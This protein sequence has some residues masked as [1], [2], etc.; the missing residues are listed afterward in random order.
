MNYG[1]LGGYTVS[2]DQTF[3]A[4]DT[5]ALLHE[6]NQST[7]LNDANPSLHY[8]ASVDWGDGTTSSP[9]M[10]LTTR[11]DPNSVGCGS[12]TYVGKHDI[13]SVRSTH[14]YASVGSF[15]GTITVTSLADATKHSTATFAVRV[16][17]PP[18]TAQGGHLFLSATG[19]VSGALV[20]FTDPDTTSMPSG[21]T[22]SVDWGDGSPVEAGLIA[23][24][25]GSFTVSGSHTY[26]DLRA[27]EICVRVVDNEYVT[28]FARACD[29]FDAPIA[30][31]GGHS[32]AGT[33]P[34]AVSGTVAAFSDP[35]ATS[36][37]ADFR[38]SI[39]WGD[40]TFA[41][42]GT[43]SGGAGSFTVAGSHTYTS[44]GSFTIT[45][46]IS[47][48]A[49]PTNSAIATD[50]ST[51][52]RAPVRAWTYLELIQDA[53]TLAVSG[54]VG[55]A[56][57]TATNAVPSEYIA[58][59]D[60]G[61]GATSA[62]TITVL[63]HL[64]GTDF[65]IA[66]S[67]T[68]ASLGVRTITMTI[69]RIGD[70][71]TAT[72]TTLVNPEITAVGGLALAGSAGQPIA[73]TLGTFS[74]ADTTTSTT[75]YRAIITWGDSGLG[76]YATITGGVGS[77]TLNGSHTYPNAGTFT[78]SVTVYDGHDIRNSATMT[79]TITIT[80][81]VTPPAIL[82]GVADANA[83]YANEVTIPCTATDAGAG[84]ADPNDGSF[85][86]RTSTISGS[87]QSAAPTDSRQ[88]CD[89][90]SNCVTAGPYTF[91]IDTKAPQ[92][93]SCEGPDGA[94]HAADATLRC[95]YTDGGSGPSTETLTL[96]TSVPVGVET[97]HAAASAGGALAC[98]AVGNCASAPADIAPN[99]ID[100]KG[101]SI[102]CVAASFTVGQSAATVTG[103][104]TDGGSGPS[105]QTVSAP[106]VTSSVGSKTLT[107]TA[108]DSVGNTS[109]QTC[110]YTVGYEFS[111][112]SAP[113]A[114]PGVV[115]TGR[116]GR[117]FP[118]RW[119]LRDST[120]ALV[121]SLDL[122]DA[123]IV[124]STSC[125]TFPAAPAPTDPAVDLRRLRYDP[126]DQQYV[127][128][129][130]SPRAKGCY[131]VFVKLAGGQLLAAHFD[132]S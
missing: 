125:G 124:S 80:V 47:A 11:G 120:G 75:D 34:A 5:L 104:A 132:L 72:A 71:S 7:F 79:D 15:T 90:S 108:T 70:S 24:G 40:G 26:A 94:W 12:S 130:Q 29:W 103:V 119:Q 19:S 65:Q 88:V 53:S 122:I 36:L 128:N 17:D 46:T 44:A 48:A 114:G 118:V 102:S 56:A 78:I 6:F 121:S 97:D 129:W 92:L 76:S 38:A 123:I 23:G 39:D 100:K 98:D 28:N 96:M 67:H 131:T 16:I 85:S 43:I 110:A 60:W 35:D 31:T 42:D 113:L 14:V 9:S 101:P 37:P 30:A 99:K 57:D 107:L 93:V 87:E 18:I 126:T 91:K 111:G 20:T 49:F 4:S 50:T 61:D 41:S 27:H 77:F 58:S 89:R 116:A 55:Y 73:A 106:A 86:L 82:C 33:A 1:P 59:I 63:G 69:T 81:D 2:R 10:T 68:Y 32:F 117:T 112:F 62:G 22:A 109:S 95:T 115:N 66:G 83:W 51:I 52:A 105:S 127:Y 3:M 84:L 8:T 13:V 54:A 25:G 45:V 74:D 21:F 64:G